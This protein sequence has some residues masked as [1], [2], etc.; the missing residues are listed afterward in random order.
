MVVEVKD[1]MVCAADVAYGTNENS[2]SVE[3]AASVVRI[4]KDEGSSL[5]R[6]FENYL[7]INALL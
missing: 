4:C 5:L 1:E 3:P 6:N 2:V 7:P